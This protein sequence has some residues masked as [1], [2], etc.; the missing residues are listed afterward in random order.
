MSDIS[1]PLKLGLNQKKENS[2][3]SLTNSNKTTS[4]NYSSSEDED[5]SD[6][7]DFLS[8]ESFDKAANQGTPASIA[9]Q[10]SA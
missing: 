7:S 5:F 3:R 1:S 8:D 4:N 6:D 10:D 9:K 2:D